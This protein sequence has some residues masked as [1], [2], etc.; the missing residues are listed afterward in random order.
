MAKNYEIQLCPQTAGFFDDLNKLTRYTD[1]LARHFSTLV[2]NDEEW[3]KRK[4]YALEAKRIEH[5]ADEVFHKFVDRLN[6]TFV[7]PFDREDLY[8]LANE[9]DNIVDQLENVMSNIVIYRVK[10]RREVLGKFTDLFLRAAR[11]LKDLIASLAQQKYS[12][13]VKQLIIALHSY[14]DEGD[15]HFARYLGE[16]FE[17]A[18][19]PL[20][21]ILWKDLIENLEQVA[22]VF[23]DV[24]NVVESVL[25]KSQ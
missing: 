19:D 18:E 22:D 7:T 5:E 14:E 25:V 13:E 20:N 10:V 12:D 11:S 1:Y 16:L 24:S 17:H 3:A 23:Q 15:V 8:L 21:V 9:L 2:N 6:R 4:A